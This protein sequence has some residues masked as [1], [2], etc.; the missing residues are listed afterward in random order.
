[1]S[2]CDYLVIGGGSGGIASARRAAARGARV[3]LV[4]KGVMGGTCVNV[5]C[6]PKKVM[7]NAA[8]ISEALEDAP[9]YGFSVEPGAFDWARVRQARD[10]YIERLNG[11]YH[12]NLKNSGVT[13]VEGKGSLLGG[14]RVQ[15]GEQ[16][17]TSKHILIATGG[18]PVRPDLPGMEL[19]DTSDDFFSWNDLPDRIAVVGAGYIAVELAGVLHALGSRVTQFIRR[20]GVLRRFDVDIHRRLLEQMRDSGI[21]FETGAAIGGIEEKPDG[22]WLRNHDRLVGPFDKV[23]VA[24]GREP[25]VRDLEPERAG[26]ALDDRGYIAV[27]DYQ[28]SR[29]PGIYAVGDVTGQAELTPVAIAAGRRLADRLFGGQTDA[30]LDY[31][32][33]ATVVFSHPPI[34][35]VGMSEQEARKVHGDEAIKVYTSSFTNMAYAV[36]RRKPGTFMKLVT[37]LPDEKVIGLHVLGTGADEMLQGFAVAV[38]MGATKQD[39][40]RTVAIHPVAAE[41]FVTMT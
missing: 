30:R 14:G 7:W 5:G 23:L 16:I 27:D 36:T 2:D 18:R 13:V 6:V 9:D 40:D 24:I 25:A 35:T 11:I 1:M 37:L 33:I 8:G 28:N 22:L 17:L 4:E 20:D 12:R 26:V 29:A 41:E 15:V 3:I 39:F 32:N 10:A 21:V 38:R 34:G 31:E 19:A